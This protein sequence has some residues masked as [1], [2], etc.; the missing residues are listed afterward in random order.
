MVVLGTGSNL[1]PSALSMPWSILT[2][3]IPVQLVPMDHP[4]HPRRHPLDMERH[5]PICPMRHHTIMHRNIRHLGKHEPWRRQS[6]TSYQA[7]RFHLRCFADAIPLD[8]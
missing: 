8:I 1:L 2:P 5:I 4:M 3:F 7:R 6:R